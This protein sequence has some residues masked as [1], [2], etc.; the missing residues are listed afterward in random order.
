MFNRPTLQQIIA[1]VAADL[2]AQLP[3][4]DARL[5]R[6]VLTVLGRTLSGAVHGL[7]GYL[8]YLALQILPD[9][10]DT[11]HLERWSAIWGLTR[12]PAA[13]AV[14]IV[15]L[16]GTDAT[17]IQAGTL[18]QR[19]DGA[20]YATDAEGVIAGGAVDLAVTAEIAGT[21]GNADAGTGLTL[22]NPIAGVNSVGA[23]AAGLSG[24]AEA[25][26]D[27]SLRSR[28]LER[29]QSPPHGGA[30][31][32]Y[33]AW[34]LAVA[35]VTRA[36][37]F[38]LNRGAGTVDLYFVCDDLAT[39]IPDAAKVAEVQAYIDTLRPVTADFQAKAPAAEPL[40]FTLQVV[41]ATAAVQAAVEAELRDLL[42]REALPGDGLDQGTILLSHIREAISA[43]AGET[44]YTLTAPVANV[45]PAAGGIVTFGAITWV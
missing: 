1:R 13:S 31:A 22:L 36:W 23:S 35:Q 38:P 42:L 16:T 3:G 33:E 43:A 15:T 11:D 39:I 19:A 6:Q 27:A 8:D 37:C 18:L 40:N 17:V 12:K 44:D 45:V 2:E 9:T 28:L 21:A 25:E 4:A 32:D 26:T 29:L 10:A 7:Y 41:P 14:G 5:R 24:G 20:E 34:A 30:A